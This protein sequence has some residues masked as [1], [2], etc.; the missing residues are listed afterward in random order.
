MISEAQAGLILDSGNL[1]GENINYVER[2][3]KDIKQIFNNSSTA[4]QMDPENIVYRVE[5]HQIVEEGK[6]GGLFFGISYLKPGKVGDEYFMTKGHF[7]SKRDTAEYYWGIS[8]HGVLL[9]MDETGECSAEYIRKGSLH[10][11]PGRIAHRL[12]NT[13]EEELI[14]GA[15]WPSDA[16]HDYGSISAHG[17]TYRV[18]ERKGKPELIKASEVEKYGEL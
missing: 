18:L 2:K 10:Y 3:L 12:V 4:D 6:P 1:S 17:F 8:G 5:S 14:V 11:I 9:L 16:G 13:G 7:H 15:C